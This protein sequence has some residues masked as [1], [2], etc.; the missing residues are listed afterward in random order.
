M[1]PPVRTLHQLTTGEWIKAEEVIGV[2]SGQ[3]MPLLSLSSGSDFFVQ[4]ASGET[5]D[6]GRDRVAK[7]VNA[8]LKRCCGATA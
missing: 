7:E 2:K 4:L 5:V 1:N 3:T 8:Y 6:Q